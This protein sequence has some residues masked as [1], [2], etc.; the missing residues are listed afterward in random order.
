MKLAKCVFFEISPNH[1]PLC[2]VLYSH[3][4]RLPATIHS[5]TKCVQLLQRDFSICAQSISFR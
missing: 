2:P 1:V 3:V 5:Y 4:K